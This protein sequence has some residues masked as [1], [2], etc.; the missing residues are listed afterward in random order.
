[1]K[2]IFLFLMASSLTI[3]ASSSYGDSQNESMKYDFRIW[4]TDSWKPPGHWETIEAK[5]CPSPM[6]DTGTDS[7]VQVYFTL[8][9]WAAKQ[10]GTQT[11]VT[12]GNIIPS[13]SQPQK[14]TTIKPNYTGTYPVYALAQWTENGK[15]Q[16]VQSNSTQFLAIA[17]CPTDYGFFYEN[18]QYHPGEIVPIKITPIFLECKRLPVNLTITVYNYTGYTKGNIM[19]Q[20]TI[21][22]LDEAWFNYTVPEWTDK[23]GVFHFLVSATWPPDPNVNAET[24]QD[25]LSSDD[26][27]I[28]A[29]Y[30]TRMWV[31]PSSFVNDGLG[32]TAIT[33]ICPFTPAT[34]SNREQ[35]RDPDTG[36]I[37]DPGSN[38]LVDYHLT[39]PNGTKKVVQESLEPLGDCKIAWSA[40]NINA[41]MVGV[42]SVYDTVKWVFKNSTH[43]LSGKPVNFTVRPALFVNKNLEE[44]D[45]KKVLSELGINGSSYLDLKDWSRDGDWILFSY[46]SYFPPDSYIQQLAIMSPDGKEVKQLSI[47][48]NFASINLARFSTSDSVLVFG[49]P[50]LDIAPQLYKFNLDDQKLVQITNETIKKQITS[51]AIT[52]D[53]NIV[54]EQEKYSDGDYL[55]YDIWLASINGTKITKLYEKSFDPKIRYSQDYDGRDHLLVQ[56]VSYD[57]K[58]IL[59]SS[60]NYTGVFDT[61]SSIGTFDIEN[62]RFDKL[63]SNYGAV[64][65]LSP[66]GNLVVYYV[67]GYKTPNGPLQIVSTDDSYHEILHSGTSASWDSTI[68]FVISPDGRFIVSEVESWGSSDQK[69]LKM[70]LAR[71]VPEFPIAGFIMVVSM[72]T[73]LIITRTKW[74]SN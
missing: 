47:P 59:V 42:W 53:D 63:F 33:K 61:R 4:P 12:H 11:F 64:Q 51:F 60:S 30:D 49:T 27:K 34:D 39:M 15:L 36:L 70:E 41:D 25:F 8:P 2:I 10:A 31:N 14:I 62:K 9:P 7:S 19:H 71:P 37:I 50:S 45:K 23:N 72:V 21:D 29:S 38:V 68:G 28:S 67:Q 26:Q 44:I 46:Q 5:I 18:R 17:P 56:D 48:M 55:G 13:C 16:K 69:L 24:H 73:I 1:M 57:G 65:R 32:T 6:P 22:I 74:N 3:F 54:Y 43:E 66:S 40:T 35:K 20:E 52:P 58:K